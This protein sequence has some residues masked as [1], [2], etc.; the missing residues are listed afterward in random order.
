MYG[1]L[2]AKREYLEENVALSKLITLL[3][4]N[5]KEINHFFKSR[6]SDIVLL[7]L[8]NLHQNAKRYEALI[9]FLYSVDTLFPLC[10]IPCMN[11]MSKGRF[12]T[13]EIFVSHFLT[14]MGKQSVDEMNKNTTWQWFF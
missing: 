3:I 13:M 2:S 6:S 14:F 4:L 9:F 5:K 11:S 8:V 10:I 1:K 12:V 7:K